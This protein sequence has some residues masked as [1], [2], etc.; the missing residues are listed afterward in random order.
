M[1]IIRSLALLAAVLALLSCS[2]KRGPAPKPFRPVPI[3]KQDNGYGEFQSAAIFT[4]AELAA[5]LDK[6]A[7]SR[8]VRK[9]EV[10]DVVE[11]AKVDFDKEALVILLHSEGS[12]FTEVGFKTPVL[13]SGKLVC[14]VTRK[15]SKGGPAATT[16][17]GFALAVRKDDVEEVEFQAEGKPPVVL[18]IR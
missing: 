7:K 2:G 6:V 1:K 8:L 12:K 3:T 9:K 14:A 18:P 11:R 17:Y 4:K 13:D 5:F 15:V 16:Y 10:K